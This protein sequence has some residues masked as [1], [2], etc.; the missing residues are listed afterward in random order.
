[1]ILL[2]SIR[3][4]QGWI[5][6]MANFLRRMDPNHVVMVGSRGWFGPASAH[7]MPY[8]PGDVQ[9]RCCVVLLLACLLACVHA[10]PPLPHQ[11]TH[12]HAQLHPCTLPKQARLPWLQQAGQRTAAPLAQL[13]PLTSAPACEGTDFLRMSMLREV[14]KVLGFATLMVCLKKWV[15]MQFMSCT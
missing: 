14:R 7:L 2:L 1:M 11:H 4:H 12:I 3:P 9:A 8:N 13:P 15:G 6:Y 5:P 10:P